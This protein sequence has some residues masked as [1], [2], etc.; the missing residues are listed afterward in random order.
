MK[1]PITLVVSLVPLTL[2]VS[3]EGP[4]YICGLWEKCPLNTCGLWEKGPRTLVISVK[5]APY[6]NSDRKKCPLHWWPVEGMPLTDT[7][8]K[9]CHWCH[10]QW[11][12]I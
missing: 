1:D 11:L 3:G 10:C 4:P 8:A 2:V 12:L 6:I 5:N 7:A 9:K